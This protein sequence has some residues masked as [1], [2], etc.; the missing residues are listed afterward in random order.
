MMAR[1][2]YEIISVIPSQRLEGGMTIVP[3]I[4]AVGITRPHDVNFSVTVDKVDGW[5]DALLAAAA[6]EAAE[7]E[8]VFD[9]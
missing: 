7:L 6:Q 5:R 2:G 1:V 9:A 8:S 4:E 3:T